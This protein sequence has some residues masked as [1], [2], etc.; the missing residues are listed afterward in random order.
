MP[1]VDELLHS[2]RGAKYFSLLDLRKAYQQLLVSEESS[3]LLGIITN[4]GI[5]EWLVLPF[6]IKTA[7][8][9]LQAR[10]EHLLRD[11]INLCVVIYL[12]DILIFT[13]DR[14]SHLVALET[15]FRRLQEAEV[16]L[17]RSK[18]KFLQTEIT[19][20]GYQLD[21]TGISVSRER[22]T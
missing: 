22:V 11:L 4:R 6:G 12:D 7:T 1:V 5:F 9:E 15:V 2:I 19:F 18:C 3:K 14:D 21:A 13:S 16:R 8:A 17:N 10:T 20:L